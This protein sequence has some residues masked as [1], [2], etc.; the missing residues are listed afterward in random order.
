MLAFLLIMT[1]VIIILNPVAPVQAVASMELL[2]STWT[3][4][5][6]NGAAEKAIGIGKILNGDFLQLTY[7]LHGL[8]LLD[9]DASAIIFEQPNGTWHFVS[10][11]NYGKNG[12]DGVQTVNIPLSDFPGLDLSKPVSDFHIRIWSSGGFSVD[13]SS[14]LIS[15]SSAALNP[16]PTPITL[17]TPV[18]SSGTNTSDAA[19]IT[20]PWTVSGNNGAVEIYQPIN[21][22]ILQDQ[23]TLTITYDLHGLKLLPGDA[24]ALIFEQPN[25]IWRFVSLSSYGRN[26]YDGVQTVNIPLSD[27]PNLNIN[28]QVG[29]LFHLRIWSGGS[30]N[31][32]IKSVSL[33][34]SVS[35]LAASPAP[36]SAPTPTPTSTPTPKATPVP[37]A[38]PASTSAP[39][40]G[41][42]WAIQSVSS[43]KQ[44]KDKICS[45]DSQS[46]INSWVD[47]AKELGANYVAVETP[48]DNPSCGDALAYTKLWVNTVRSRGMKVW[49]RHMPLAHEGIYS[50]TKTKGDYFN[51]I[52]N[53]IKNNS[54]LFAEGD[55]FTPI[56]EPQNGGIS[57]ITYC[58]DGVC[59]YDNIASFNKWLRDAM[60][61]SE[62]AFGSIGLG[63]KMKLGYY[64]FDGFVAWGSNNPDW[65]GILE[66]A[67]IAKMGNIAIDHYP[68]LIGQTMKQGLDEVQERYPGV[69]IFISEWGS[70]GSSNWEQQVIDSMGASKRPG[71]VGFNYWHMGMG[72]NESLIN[73]DFTNRVQFDEVQSFF[74]GTR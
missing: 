43:M 28:N 52:S 4:S 9:K 44:T 13:F 64:G 24:S 67:T 69:P 27:F 58:A 55:I 19:I 34:G 7:N 61:I 31:I 65:N 32:D 3:L 53:Y 25:G 62:T 8:K 16:S 17:A 15:N 6:N 14:A 26:G 39:L 51:M 70:T 33:N 12:Y 42:S 30:F 10:L 54:P 18:P 36:S 21:K 37:T 50:A 57:G 22:N 48:Y 49:H 2:S 5:G 60:S 71:V 73:S 59:Q 20:S 63:G 74:K 56:P 1:S 68:E 38:A 46:F 11:S 47:K 40:T 41:S 72:G 35:A 66:D 23:K 45:Q 29:P